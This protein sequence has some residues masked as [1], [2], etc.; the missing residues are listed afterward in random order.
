[1]PDKSSSKN[2]PLRRVSLSAYFSSDSDTD[3]EATS[4][5]SSSP[6]APVHPRKTRRIGYSENKIITHFENEVGP[7][8]IQSNT[9]QA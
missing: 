4:S 3:T 1:M 5:D 7:G 9:Q 6:G 8:V 2:S